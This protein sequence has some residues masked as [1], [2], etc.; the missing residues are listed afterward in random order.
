MSKHNKSNVRDG[1][2]GMKN[3]EQL[4]NDLEKIT[5]EMN[6]C[7]EARAAKLDELAKLC[8]LKLGDKV[9][10]N[11]GYS[12]EGKVILIDRV[13]YS[14]YMNYSWAERKGRKT[15]FMC[16]GFILKKDG[17]AGKNRG[18]HRC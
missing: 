11:S 13:C 12:Y 18:E 3:L 15:L 2:L 14:D 9:D 6:A 17:T 16:S 4:Q 7:K 1:E 8:P 5:S 10:V